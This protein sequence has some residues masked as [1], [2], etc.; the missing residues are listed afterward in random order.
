MFVIGKLDPDMSE[1]KKKKIFE[2]V[3]LVLF[4]MFLFVP[5][6]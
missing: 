6:E 3:V 4:I 2:G 1:E 5:T